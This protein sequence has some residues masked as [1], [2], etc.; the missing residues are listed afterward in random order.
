MSEFEN[1]RKKVFDQMKDNSVAL[2]FSGVSKIA[3]EDEYLPFVVNK[4]FYYLTGIKQEHSALMLIKAIGERRAYLFIDPYS[5]LKEKWTGKRLTQEQATYISGLNS[6]YTSDNLETMLSLALTN[7]NNQYGD[8][9]CVYLDLTSP[10]QKLK[11][12]MFMNDLS[13]K[14]Q[15]DY[16]KT[17]IDSYPILRDLRMVKSA[18]EVECLVK[19]IERTNNGIAFA[20]NHLKVG[21]KEHELADYFELYGRL[22]ERSTLAFSTIVASGKNATCLHYPSQNDTVKEN[23]LILFDLGYNHEE[24]SADISRTFPVNGKFEGVQ[25]KIYEAVLNCNKA[26][27]QMI[28]PGLTIK[29]LQEFATEF[30]RKQCINS[31][32][33][34]IND[35]IRNYYYHNVSHHLGLDTHDI[36]LREKPLQNGNVITVEPGLYFAKYGVG[37]RIEDDV[38]VSED[39]AVV[40]SKNIAKEMVDVERMMATRI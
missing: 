1:R 9:D 15:L 22:H 31:G 11:E 8:I 33:M 12:G 2:F 10:E 39:G 38:L 17:V 27:I 36:S 35:D 23:D 29:D 7:E 6:V 20:L 5:E 34:D 3:S 25:A 4:N 40:L 21:M 18:A 26:V 19:A 37:V 30:L 13:V 24:Y 16:Q 32:L 28:K 14:I